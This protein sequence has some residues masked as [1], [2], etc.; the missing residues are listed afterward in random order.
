MVF[1][2][3]FSSLVLTSC[4]KIQE[5]G[6]QESSEEVRDYEKMLPAEIQQ[7]ATKVMLKLRVNLARCI[8]RVKV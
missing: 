1:P 2:I 4:Q 8:I 6:S 3:V 7:L 5:I